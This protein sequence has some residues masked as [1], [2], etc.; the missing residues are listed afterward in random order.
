MLGKLVDAIEQGNFAITVVDII[1]LAERDRYRYVSKFSYLYDLDPKCETMCYKRESDRLEAVL[2]RNSDLSERVR[3]ATNSI[4]PTA[5]TLLNARSIHSNPSYN[6]A[7]DNLPPTPVHTSIVDLPTEL[8]YSI[9]RYAAVDSQA[10]TAGQFS[11]LM[12]EAAEKEGL[13][14]RMSQSKSLE[15]KI[16]T[17]RNGVWKWKSSR[18]YVW[19]RWLTQENLDCWGWNSLEVGGPRIQEDESVK[20]DESV[21]L[22]LESNNDERELLYFLY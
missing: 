16:Y 22:D 21:S 4:L 9:I 1:P 5:R 13:R 20:E 6:I 7:T 10:V 12:E 18:V 17:I 3:L 14:F 11:C 2:G 19:K 8:L 15:Y